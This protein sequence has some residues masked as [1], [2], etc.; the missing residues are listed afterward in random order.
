[1]D[2]FLADLAADVPPGPKCGTAKVLAALDDDLRVQVQ[3]A[4]DDERYTSRGIAR[5]LTKRGHQITDF[6]VN[7]HR[8]GECRCLR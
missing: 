5:Q 2:D 3:T 4:L 6:T 1:M 8:K 7:R